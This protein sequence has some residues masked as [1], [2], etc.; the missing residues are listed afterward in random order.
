MPE[1]AGPTLGVKRNCTSQLAQNTK[2]RSGVTKGGKSARWRRPVVMP[3]CRTKSRG[4]QHFRNHKSD[5][6]RRLEESNAGRRSCPNQAIALKMLSISVGRLGFYNCYLC[7]LLEFSTQY[8][9]PSRKT[10][11]EGAH[12]QK[13][14]RDPTARGDSHV[15]ARVFQHDHSNR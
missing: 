7:C 11:R 13:D 5:R 9:K 4:W 6:S 3:A 14:N 12:G 8:R 2:A 1:L 10:C 15:C